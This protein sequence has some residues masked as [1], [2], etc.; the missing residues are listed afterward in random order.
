MFSVQVPPLCFANLEQN[1]INLR[2]GTRVPALLQGTR[3][4]FLRRTDDWM[5]WCEKKHIHFDAE[6]LATGFCR[7]L[8]AFTPS[9]DQ[10]LFL[11]LF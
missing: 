10:A 6:F 9:S 3:A 7:I 1:L 4:Q 11:G 8:E 2:Q 5:P